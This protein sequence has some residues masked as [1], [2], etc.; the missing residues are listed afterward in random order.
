MAGDRSAASLPAERTRPASRPRVAWRGRKTALFS[1]VVAVLPPRHVTIGV[2]KA[3][4]KLSK[5]RLQGFARQYIHH[6]TSISWTRKGDVCATPPQPN[7]NNQSDQQSKQNRA[8]NR[9]R[10][11]ARPSPIL[12][13]PLTHSEGQGAASAPVS[14]SQRTDRQGASTCGPAQAQRPQPANGTT[15]TRSTK[16]M[17]L[18]H[19][20]AGIKTHSGN[21]Y[22][23][24]LLKGVVMSDLE[25]CWHGGDLKRGGERG[26]G[27]VIRPEPLLRECT[28]RRAKVYST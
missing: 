7:R 3:K 4:Q 5:A 26:G 27:V 25:G 1:R 18:W 19:P 22:R 2:G 24:Q 20:P 17:A 6:H 23:S 15:R 9:R 14:A 13:G 16:C 21:Y 10:C 12:F 8:D 28:P 11:H